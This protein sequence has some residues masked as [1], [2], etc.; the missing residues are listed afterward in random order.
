MWLESWRSFLATERVLKQFSNKNNGE[1][2]FMTCRGEFD[3]FTKEIIEKIPQ[4]LKFIFC[5]YVAEATDKAVQLLSLK[6]DL[7]AA[8]MMF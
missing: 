6:T 5:K 1:E 3:K 7:S 4:C 8:K 2:I